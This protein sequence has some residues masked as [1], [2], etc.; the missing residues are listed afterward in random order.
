MQAQPLKPRLLATIA[1]AREREH[2]L[3][4]MA[5]D[6]PP[7]E[8]GLWTVKDHLAHLTWWRV[9]AA[10]VLDS[11][12]TGSTLPDVADED[13]VQNEKIYL[14]NETKKAEAVKAESRASYDKLEAAIA[15]SSERD[16]LG[17]HPR[18]PT[19]AKL[20]QL[21]PGNGHYHLGQHLMF[22][23]LEQGDEE[24]AEV[25]QQWVYDLDR[26]EF[27]DPKSVASSTYNMACFYSRVGRDDEALHWLKH[28]FEL[29][30]ALKK[31]ARTDTDLVRIRNHADFVALI[32]D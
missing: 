8:P 11:V 31:T 24:A 20:W 1:A 4:A 15:A 28:A 29:D 23:H 10:D 19:A 14:A 16:L 3:L 18:Y 7:P 22:W 32:A 25:A 27:P 21:I 12:R 13:D 5:D 26:A 9:Y 2:E 30:P 6:S 17:P